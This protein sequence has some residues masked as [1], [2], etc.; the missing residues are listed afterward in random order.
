MT[1]QYELSLLAERDVVDIGW[2]VALDNPR[3]AN[4]LIDRFFEVFALLAQHPKMGR[5]REE[6]RDVRSFAVKPYVI[7]Y[8]IRDGG[9]EIARVLHG[10]RDLSGLFPKRL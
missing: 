1:L 9:I 5:K 6:F 3:A 7:F 4:R 10:A 8:R 2:S